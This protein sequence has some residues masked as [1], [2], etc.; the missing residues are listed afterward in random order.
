MIEN[1]HTTI[2]VLIVTLQDQADQKAKRMLDT[3]KQSIIKCLEWY[4][5]CRF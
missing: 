5:I 2:V 3:R 1:S 4:Y